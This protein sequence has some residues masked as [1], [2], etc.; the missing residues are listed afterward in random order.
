MP[1]VRDDMTEEEYIAQFFE[2]EEP[3][4]DPELEEL[5]RLTEIFS[6]LDKPAKLTVFTGIHRGKSLTEL[7]EEVDVSGTS[8]HNYVNDMIDANIVVRSDGEYHLS[9]LGEWILMAVEGMDQ[10][11]K[12][13]AIK[14][15]LME[16]P[17]DLGEE[18][19]NVVMEKEDMGS[20][21]LSIMDLEKFN[22]F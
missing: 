5:E 11:V 7:K 12:Y 21:D 14:T 8:V 17:G 19:V 6:V 20:S 2:H 3:S 16:M 1:E 10:V 22:E 18:V 15:T 13:Y 4:D 9:S